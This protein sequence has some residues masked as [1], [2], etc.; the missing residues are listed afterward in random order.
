MLGACVVRRRA[1]ALVAVAAS[2]VVLVASCTPGADRLPEDGPLAVPRSDG[3]VR[4]VTLVAEAGP[5]DRAIGNI[6]ATNT[7]ESDVVITTVELVDPVNVRLGD[8]VLVPMAASGP[9]LGAGYPVPP[10]GTDDEFD[11][12]DAIWERSSPLIGTPIEPG[13]TVNLVVGLQQVDKSACAWLGST[14]FAYTAGGTTFRTAWDTSYAFTTLDGT[15][16]A[17][18][19]PTG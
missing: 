3:A 14:R 5:R 15:E 19:V 7:G 2:G 16:C 6:T 18:P 13:E 11:R 17:D 1:R 10:V 4:I 12:L 8:A 9:T